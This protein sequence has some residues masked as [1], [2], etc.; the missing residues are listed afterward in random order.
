MPLMQAG[1]TSMGAARFTMRLRAEVA[2]G[3]QVLPTLVF[4]QPTVRTLAVHLHTVNNKDTTLAPSHVDQ[5]TSHIL[6]LAAEIIGSAHAIASSNQLVRVAD[7]LLRVSA[8]TSGY[9]WPPLVG[10]V[11]IHLA[12]L[13]C[14]VE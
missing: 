6:A 2:D 11:A 7:C 1:L 13:G 8:G 9:A 5:L 10:Y 14:H 3:A 4:E 12:S